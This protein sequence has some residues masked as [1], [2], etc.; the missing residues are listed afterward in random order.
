[1]KQFDAFSVILCVL[2]R[3]DVSFCFHLRIMQVHSVC[4]A[5]KTMQKLLN[6]W[7]D[8]FNLSVV[9]SGDLLT[10]HSPVRKLRGENSLHEVKQKV[11]KCH[12]NGLV[13]ELSGVVFSPLHW[14]NQ[15]DSLEEIFF[16]SID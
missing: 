3:V 1:M 7:I 14:L 8:V 2:I 15:V 6:L 10:D 4:L 13:E 12:Q 11:V 16:D 5:C 9:V